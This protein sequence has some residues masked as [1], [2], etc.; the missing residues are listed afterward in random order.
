MTNVERLNFV[1]WAGKRDPQFTL[2]R[3]AYVTACWAWRS[4]VRNDPALTR[5]IK[6]VS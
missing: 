2:S 1:V 4:V 6:P 5:V 3:K